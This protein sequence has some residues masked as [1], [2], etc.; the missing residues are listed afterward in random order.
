MGVTVADPPPRGLSGRVLANQR[1]V[2]LHRAD[3][4]APQTLAAYLK[5][6]HVS[7]SFSGGEQGYVDRRLEAIGCRRNV[8]AWT[9]RF[10]AIPDL[11]ARTG[12]IATLP[13]P[14]AAAFS[15]DGVAAMAA[16]PFDLPEVSVWQCWHLRR[17]ADP[18]NR[19]VRGHIDTVMKQALAVSDTFSASGS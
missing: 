2:V 9:P 3:L 16:C 14:I 5:R 11:V 8:I 17:Q 1:F 15:A 12:A 19:W 13:E 10:T 6:D 7:V 4:A 18:L